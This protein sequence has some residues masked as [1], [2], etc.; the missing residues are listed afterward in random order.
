MISVFILL[1]AMLLIS[2]EVKVASVLNQALRHEDWVN[3][4]IAHAFLTS[5][6]DGSE[7]SV[8]CPGHFTQK[9]KGGWFPEAVWMRW[10]RGLLLCTF[11]HGFS[12][13]RGNTGNDR[14]VT[15][16]LRT[17]YS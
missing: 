3:G 6:L 10:L 11:I 8:L 15:R 1:C 7:Y 9:K 14:F 13:F 5:A 2:V 12:K 17:N 16:L 4:G